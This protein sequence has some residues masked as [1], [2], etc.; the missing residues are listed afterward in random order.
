MPIKGGGIDWTA[1]TTARMKGWKT[2]TF[3][4][5]TFTHHRKMG[6]W[7]SNQIKALFKHG[8]KDYFLGGHPLWQFFRFFYQVK[9]KPF[10]FGGLLL[11]SGYAWGWASGAEKPISQELIDF[12]RQE[13]LNR[14]KVFFRGLL[15]TK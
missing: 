8:L 9:K 14:L 6:T 11:L 1:V 3:I 4:E 13:Q 12:V 15:L 2:R 5:R 7:D 10:I